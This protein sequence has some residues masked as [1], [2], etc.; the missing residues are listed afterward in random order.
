MCGLS[1]TNPMDQLHHTKYPNTHA[2]TLSLSILVCK[3]V[4]RHFDYSAIVCSYRA[5]PQL[6]HMLPIAQVACLTSSFHA[7]KNKIHNVKSQISIKLSLSELG[8]IEL[9]AHHLFLSK[10]FHSEH[11]KNIKSNILTKCAGTSDSMNKIPC[12]LYI[13][14]N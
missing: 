13:T 1:V 12:I 11:L 8:A 7:F 5:I 6:F 14:H 4:L 2:P 9:E 10:C 3:G